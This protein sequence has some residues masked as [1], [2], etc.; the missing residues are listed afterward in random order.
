MS[1]QLQLTSGNTT[2]EQAVVRKSLAQHFCFTMN[3]SVYSSQKC[4][5][6][7]PDVKRNVVQL[8]LT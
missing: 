4:C 2:L 3:L 5:V 6:L 7:P 1:G 8:G